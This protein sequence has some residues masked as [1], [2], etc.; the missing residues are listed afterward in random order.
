MLTHCGTNKV[1]IHYPKKKKKIPQ[2]FVSPECIRTIK[3]IFIISKKQLH[4]H[5]HPEHAYKYEVK[6]LDH[7]KIYT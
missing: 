6:I 1:H 2:L 4:Q 5:I 3:D 7:K